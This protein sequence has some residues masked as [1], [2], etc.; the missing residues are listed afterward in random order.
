MP[1]KKIKLPLLGREMDATEVGILKK[2]E[3]MAEYELED[4]A[5]IRYISYPT[6]VLRLD[7]Q[8]NPDGTPV[9]LVLGSPVTAVVNV[10]DN[11]KNP[12]R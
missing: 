4:G 12:K 1:E 3:Q 6:S 2:T 9:Y 10:P 5:T 11:L 7:G 8:Y